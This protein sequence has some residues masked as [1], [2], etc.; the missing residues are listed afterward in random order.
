MLLMDKTKYAGVLRITNAKKPIQNR[1][2]VVDITW[3]YKSPYF[4]TLFST[5]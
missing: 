3:K 1:R 2:K 5:R 4:L